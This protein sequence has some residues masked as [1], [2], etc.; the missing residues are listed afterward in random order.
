MR[1]SA[2]KGSVS[3]PVLARVRAFLDATFPGS[4]LDEG[5]YL[6]SIK[7]RAGRLVKH[8]AF[9]RVADHLSE[10]NCWLVLVGSDPRRHVHARAAEH[11][12]V[13]YTP[14]WSVC[15]KRTQWLLDLK[16]KPIGI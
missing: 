11:R 6:V 4:N 14:D 5:Y 13:Y 12:D 3:S 10:R 9:Q 16:A 8:S 1:R 15:E 7:A 2:T